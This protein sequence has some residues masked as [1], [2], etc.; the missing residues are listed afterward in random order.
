[1]HIGMIY[2]DNHPFPPDIRI[3]KEMKALCAVGH[4]ITILAPRIPENAAEKEVLIPNL[5]E[6]RR[7][8]ITRPNLFNRL[9]Q[10]VFLR[11][12]NW[13]YPL[14]DFIKRCSP[15]F[16]HVHDLNLLP[17][18]LR[19]SR[20]FD[21]P[22]VADLHENMPAARRAY[23]SNLKFFPKLLS[24]MVFNYHFWR[25][26]E[27]RAL[28]QCDRIIVVVP[29]AAERLYKYGIPKKNVVVV[30][31]TEDETTFRAQPEKAD[32]DT[33]EKYRSFWVANYIGGISP[34]RGLDTT[35]RALPIAR[36]KISNLRLVIVGANNHNRQQI[37]QMAQRHG[38]DDIVEIIDWQP[39]EKINSYIFSSRVCL[40]PHNDF[41]HTQTTVPHKLFQYMICSK[42]VLVSNCRPLARIVNETQ[43][44]LVFEADNSNDLANKL[45]KLYQEPEQA[46]IMGQNGWHAA[47]GSYAWRHDAKRLIQMYK[48]LDQMRHADSRM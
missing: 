38:V 39:F 28:R 23:R 34:H 47:L 7:V 5:V 48:E 41:E 20:P 31:N 15:D 21:L 13:I 45:I 16:L 42:P 18:T 40:V 6:V 9:Q 43:S 32:N 12:S 25:W 8:S 44:G 30:S 19:V 26:H 17:T 24:A 35:I 10:A 33:L 1:M 4:H 29:E 2:G 11:Y 37:T 46:S 14:T 36:N 3:E 27:A 22:V